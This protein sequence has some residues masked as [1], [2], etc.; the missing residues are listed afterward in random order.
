VALVLVL[1]YIALVL[2]LICGLFLFLAL[3]IS[4]SHQPSDSTM[5][6]LSRAGIRSFFLHLQCFVKNI[7]SVM[8]PMCHPFQTNI[9][10]MCHACEM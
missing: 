8:K 7:G 6:L 4:A 5:P 3:G 1:I 10:H 9:S 2:G